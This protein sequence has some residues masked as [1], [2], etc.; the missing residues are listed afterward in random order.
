MLQF[1]SK[2]FLRMAPNTTAWTDTVEAF[3][4]GRGYKLATR[5][6]AQMLCFRFVIR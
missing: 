1:A 6:P 4:D 2:L 5:V 3:L